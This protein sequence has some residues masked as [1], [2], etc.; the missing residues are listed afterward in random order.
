M[1]Y[2]VFLEECPL[3]YGSVEYLGNFSLG[4]DIRCRGCHSIF[5]EAIWQMWLTIK[6][7]ESKANERDKPA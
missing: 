3:C 2:G 5:T 7:E 1:G 4:I 6:A